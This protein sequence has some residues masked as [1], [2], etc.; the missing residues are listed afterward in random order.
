MS[1]DPGAAGESVAQT[2]SPAAPAGEGPTIENI[3]A[4]WHAVVDAV[5]QTQPSA[6]NFLLEGVLKSFDGGVLILGYPPENS[7]HMAQVNKSRAAVEAALVQ[8]LGQP[9][10]LRCEESGEPTQAPPPSR[11]D[12]Q[13]VD[14][15]LKSVLDALDGELV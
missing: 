14:P 8:V 7:F 11:A 4:E 15:T 12:E 6:A 2:T 5:R 3:R 13:A 1:N 10:R 9:M